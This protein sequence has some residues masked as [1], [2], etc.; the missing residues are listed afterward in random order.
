MG[1]FDGVTGLFENVFDSAVTLHPD[2]GA[3]V[4]IRGIFREEPVER[5]DLDGPE[6]TVVS[7]TLKLRADAAALVARGTVLSVEDRPGETFK[8]VAKYPTRSPA[9]DRHF[10]FL[11]TEVDVA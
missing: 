3:D 11:L 9:A 4:T 5:P 10:L 7:P 8:V 1:L 6:I 2:G